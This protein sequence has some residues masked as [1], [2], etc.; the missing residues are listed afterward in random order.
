MFVFGHKP[1]YEYLIVGLGN[2]GP[3]YANTRHNA[4][5]LAVRYL[6]GK[7]SAS[8]KSRF[9]SEYADVTLNGARCLLQMPQTFMNNSGE[10]VGAL[11]R[12]YKLP[13]ERVIVLH[14]DIT[15]PPGRIKIKTGG[16]CGGH[17]G[18]ASIENHLGSQNYTHVKIGI[19]AKPHPEM[20][21]AEFV[22]GLIPAEDRRQIEE[23]FP[24]IAGA[25]ELLCA[26]QTEKAKATYNQ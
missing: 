20:P 21:L 7:Y 12:Y 26:G 13:P 18:L 14:D 25:L 6:S 10:A 1:Q 24:D 22:L 15:L 23:R 9:K 11:C 17:N 2:P 8:F 19:G 4:G 16:S 5:F 3:T